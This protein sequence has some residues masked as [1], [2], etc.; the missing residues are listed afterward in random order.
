MPRFL[1]FLLMIVVIASCRP[2][3][4]DSDIAQEEQAVQVVDSIEESTALTQERSTDNMQLRAQPEPDLSPDFPEDQAVE[5][6][7]AILKNMCNNKYGCLVE[8]LYP[9]GWSAD[10]KFAYL[11]E[12]A[13]EA[14]Q[15]TTIHFRVQDT[16]SDKILA[17]RT[18]K[19]SDQPEYTEENDNYSVM[20]IWRAQE[21]Q[22]DSLLRQYNVQLGQGTEFYPIRESGSDWPYTFTDQNKMR[23]NELFGIKEVD[24]H[25]LQA[26]QSGVGEKMILQQQYG[27]YDL[28]IR[29]GVLGYF[30]SPFEERIAVLDGME[31]RGYE[32][33]PN[34]LKLQLVGCDLSKGFE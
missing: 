2:K 16:E 17:E 24:Q 33:P 12:E 7:G 5:P 9:L 1:V 30:K 19:A 8:K 34:V 28:V 25:R 31:K 13:N 15:N 27:K 29:T 4:A 10:G 3:A 22:Y 11:L 20:G 32:G 6:D 21:L 14:V 23:K 26:V 18:F